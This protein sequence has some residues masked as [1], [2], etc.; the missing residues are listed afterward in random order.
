MIFKDADIDAA[1]PVLT[2]AILLNA[3]QECMSGTRI[4][5][6]EEIYDQLAAQARREPANV[7]ARRRL[8]PTPSSGP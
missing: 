3:G 4:L 5:V 2:N 6:A 1:L 7:E 8:I